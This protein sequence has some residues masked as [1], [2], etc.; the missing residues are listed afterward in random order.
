MTPNWKISSMTPSIKTALHN[1]LSNKTA[2]NWYQRLKGHAGHKVYKCHA[3]HKVYKCHARHKVKLK[4]LS[5]N[6]CTKNKISK[7]LFWYTYILNVNSH[8]I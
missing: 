6:L 7:V 8:G 3:R 4:A 1:T 2:M 5:K